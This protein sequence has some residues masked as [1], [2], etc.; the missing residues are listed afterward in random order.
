MGTA[1]KASTVKT[2]RKGDRPDPPG[3]KLAD[4]HRAAIG[5]WLM[6]QYGELCKKRY[7]ALVLQAV[8]D[9]NFKARLMANPDEVFREHKIKPPKGLRIRVVEDTPSTA[10]LVLPDLRKAEAQMKRVDLKLSEV[11]GVRGGFKGVLQDNVFKDP[12]IK[13]DNNDGGKKADKPRVKLKRDH[14]HPPDGD[15]PERETVQDPDHGP[16][17]GYYRHDPDG[18]FRDRLF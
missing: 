9:P 2:K 12:D 7:A 14:H 4:E 8:V 6:R 10:W 18:D 1:K 5:N 17:K 15:P 13:S 11:K 3:Q 16:D